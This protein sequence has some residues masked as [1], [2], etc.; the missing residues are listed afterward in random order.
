MLYNHLRK[1][2][3]V[4]LSLAMMCG[5]LTGFAS[6]EEEDTAIDDITVVEET[7]ESDGEAA[8]VPE[9][10]VTDEVSI[11]PALGTDDDEGD[12]LPI[13][14]EG[15]TPIT[16][17][18]KSLALEGSVKVNFYLQIP[19][20]FTNKTGAK[21]VVED[22]Y[23]GSVT[24]YDVADI[25]TVV[26]SGVTYHHLSF[27]IAVKELRRTFTVTPIY[28]DDRI[29]PMV[30]S[31][32]VLLTDGLV[33]SAQTYINNKVTDDNANLVRLVKCLSEYGSCAQTYFN[34]QTETIP[35]HYDDIVAD[36]ANVTASDLQAYASVKEDTSEGSDFSYGG[37]SLNLEDVTM[38]NFNFTFKN[39]AE[40]SDF[41]YYVDSG[42][43]YEEVTSSTG[44]IRIEPNPAR[45]GY[46]RVVIDNIAAKNLNKMYTLKVTDL[47]GTTLYTI[48]YSA[49]SYAYSKI[50]S[51]KQALVD[52]VKSMYLYHLAAVDYF[53]N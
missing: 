26:R 31:K 18:G 45:S 4:S 22:S 27:S 25:P 7:E 10:V 23:D 16:V 51:D 50:D 6:Y 2:V 43:G 40:V 1:A 36:I 5:A 9:E 20:E 12:E 11:D 8:I 42:N 33:Y 39:D 35:A 14:P 46:Y 32:G 19:Q 44:L 29:Y 34:F 48:S 30:D 3:C 28:E 13:I 38:I 49:L 41:K 47:S 53:N 15:E 21:I 17:G 37:T 52:T 24:D